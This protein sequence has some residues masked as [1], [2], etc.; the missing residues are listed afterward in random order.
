M[1]KTYIAQVMLSNIKEVK[2]Q[3]PDYCDKHAIETQAEIEARHHSDVD[4]YMI[5]CLEYKEVMD[6]GRR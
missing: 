5:E 6:N 2:F 1:M 3:L 4:Y